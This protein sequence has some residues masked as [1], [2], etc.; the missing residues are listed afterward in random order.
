MPQPIL[1]CNTKD[2]PRKRWLECRKHGPN[3]D[4]PFTLGG[5]D[6]ATVF[7]INPWKTPLELF[8]EKRDLLAPNEDENAKQKN[9]G[10]LLEPVVADVFATET[11][12]EIIEDYG[13]YQHAEY[14]FAIADIDYLYRQGTTE[15]VLE[16]KSTTYHKA[17][18]Y[19]NGC[20]PI[21]YELQVRFYLEVRQYETG[22]LACLWGNNP[23][24]DFVH[25]TIRYDKHISQEILEGAKEFIHRLENNDPPP[26]DGVPSKLAIKAL[27]RIYD[28]VKDSP[29]VEFSSAHEPALRKIVELQKQKMELKKKA[30]LLAQSIEELSVPF[31][32]LLKDNAHGKLAVSNGSI[33]VDFTQQSKRIVDTKKLQKEYPDIY[34]EVQKTSVVWPFKVRCYEANRK[35]GVR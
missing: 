34:K 3:G 14:P 31:R 35:T 20:T 9:L 6:I 24:T 12:S 2:M 8:M 5:S 11:G 27:N 16:C 33:F 4:I 1:L 32:E 13:M 21:H 26:M 10:H 18:D 7:G 23:D 25:R 22:E 17:G 30:D 15:G 28:N 29:P 19:Q